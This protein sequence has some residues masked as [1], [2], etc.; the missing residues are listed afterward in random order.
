MNHDP[1]DATGWQ[2]DGSYVPCPE[3]RW[4]PPVERNPPPGRPVRLGTSHYGD[5][6]TVPRLSPESEK[7]LREDLREMD[8]CRARAWAAAQHY[9]IGRA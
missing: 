1:H 3:C 9:V 5:C 4:V 6:P 7:R 2:A 8:R